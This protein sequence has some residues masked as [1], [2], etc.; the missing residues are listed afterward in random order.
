MKINYFFGYNEV[1]YWA[2]IKIIEKVSFVTQ[3]LFWKDY[4]VVTYGTSEGKKAFF[5]QGN[6]NANRRTKKL[7]CKYWHGKIV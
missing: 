5:T 4:R 7:I 2:K 6:I 3:S 1:F